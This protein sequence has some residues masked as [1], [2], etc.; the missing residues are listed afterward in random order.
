MKQDLK[1][2]QYLVHSIL[3]VVEKVS[4]DRDLDSL[5]IIGAL[6]AAKFVVIDTFKNEDNEIASMSFKGIN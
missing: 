3:A 4:N 6:E 1:N 2:Y 5:E